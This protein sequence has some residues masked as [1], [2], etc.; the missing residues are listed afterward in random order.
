[1]AVEGAT[2]PERDRR[3]PTRD[4]KVAVC[5]PRHHR[6]PERLQE[7]LGDRR[8]GREPGRVRGHPAEQRGTQ[9][10]PG[11][12]LGERESV[13]SP[14]RLGRGQRGAQWAPPDLSRT[15]LHQPRG[16]GHPAA[17]LTHQDTSE[18]PS[19]TTAPT[20]PAWGPTQ[21]ASTR[22][23]GARHVAPLCPQ[24]VPGPSDLSAALDCCVW[25]RRG[26]AGVTSL[27]DPRLSSRPCT[28]R[29]VQPCPLLGTADTSGSLRSC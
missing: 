21:T 2:F 10:R 20:R 7:L 12:A 25:A 8:P 6:A 24:R 28:R 14:V 22:M 17:D 27:R 15:P 16:A 1:M 5:H 4:S 11:Q 26:Q 29:R 13:G 23:P 19:R 9:S 3:T 18:L